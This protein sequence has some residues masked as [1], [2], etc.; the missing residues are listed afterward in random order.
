MHWASQLPGGILASKYGTKFIFGF[1]NFFACVLCLFMPLACYLNYR[2]MVGLRLVQGLIA[3]VAWPGKIRWIRTS[4]SLDKNI[5]EAMHNLTGKWI[6]PNERS[7]FVTAY[8]GGSMGAAIAYPLFGLIIRRLSWEYVFH[9]CGILGIIWYMFWLRFVSSV[10]FSAAV[11]V[12]P[13]L[14]FS[15]RFTIHPK[16]IRESIQKSA[17]TFSKRSAHRS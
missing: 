3:G 6:P 16:S 4:Q 5:F 13:Y 14:I 17:S 9:T 2:W 10:K 11:P 12:L 1:A 8:P 15:S 7:K